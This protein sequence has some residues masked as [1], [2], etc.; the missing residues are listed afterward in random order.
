MVQ[1][2]VIYFNLQSKKQIIFQFKVNFLPKIDKKTFLQIFKKRFLN[3]KYGTY[4]C[5]H[6]H[7]QN[8]SLTNI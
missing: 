3:I 4:T 1:I 2:Y 8:T 7:N 5:M 6:A